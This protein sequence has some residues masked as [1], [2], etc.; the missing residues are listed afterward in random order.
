[1]KKLLPL[2]EAL[3]LLPLLWL[4]VSRVDAQS[5]PTSPPPDELFRTIAALDGALFDAFN[6]CDLEKFGTFLS[7]DHH[8][9]AK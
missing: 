9:L 6:R 4:A 7:Y 3:L 5:A 1:M 2:R 8:A